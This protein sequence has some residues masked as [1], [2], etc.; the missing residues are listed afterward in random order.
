MNP[1]LFKKPE[2]I[3]PHRLPNSRP[4]RAAWAGVLFEERL[5]A[6]LPAPLPVMPG[7]ALPLAPHPGP[8]LE[9]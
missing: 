3:I 6:L 2:I 8:W 9:V 7:K 4:S 5:L 1:N